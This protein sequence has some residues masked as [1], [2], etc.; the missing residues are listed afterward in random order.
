M[1]SS[2]VYFKIVQLLPVDGG[3]YV[4]MHPV[5]C[6]MRAGQR[7]ELAVRAAME[8][9][10]KQHCSLKYLRTKTGRDLFDCLGVPVGDLN[11][12][13]SAVVHWIAAPSEDVT[14]RL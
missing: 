3:K 5:Q 12:G 13:H 6:S 8:R 14:V 2:A 11:L 4:G 7:L 10:G 9:A 1:A